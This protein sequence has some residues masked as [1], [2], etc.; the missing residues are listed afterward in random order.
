MSNYKVTVFDR[1]DRTA[2]FVKSSLDYDVSTYGKYDPEI[3]ED[4][5]LVITEVGSSGISPE[6][7]IN[8]PTILHS[9]PWRIEKWEEKRNKALE[10]T[11][12][13]DPNY[14]GPG[15]K[16]H[17]DDL[18]FIE[19]VNGSEGLKELSRNLLEQ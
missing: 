10:G 6:A 19:K 3:A 7:E 5:D 17:E 13:R 9:I 4:S 15:E 11:T 18:F 2:E 8:T 12:E 1:D 14:E 16:Y